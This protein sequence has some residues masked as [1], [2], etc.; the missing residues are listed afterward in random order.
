[1]PATGSHQ[2]ASSIE[3]AYE[4]V[5]VRIDSNQYSDG[6]FLATATRYGYRHMTTESRAI[7][8]FEAGCMDPF[9]RPLFRSRMN[10]MTSYLL[11][12]GGALAR[13]A[14]QG[15][16]TVSI[17]SQHPEDLDDQVEEIFA[18]LPKPEDPAVRTGISFWFREDHGGHR[19]MHRR[20]DPRPWSEIAQGYSEGARDRLDSLMAMREIPHAG[21]LILWH[22]APGTG[23]THALRALAHEW[24]DWCSLHV[25]TDPEHFVGTDVSYLM[26]VLEAMDP[27]SRERD[28]KRLIVLEDAG[29]LL[30][31]DARNQT[32]QGLSRLLNLTDGLI[33]T[34]TNAMV[35]IS[36]NEPVSR[37]H[38]AVHRPGRCFSEIEIGPLS[39]GEANAWLADRGSRTRVSSPRTLAQL[40]A[41]LDGR[42]EGR[43]E[44]QVGFAA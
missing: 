13:I 42:P 29:E 3:L 5:G 39:A 28:R 7:G 22:G 19:L 6:L 20:I 1:M 9:E 31:A 25:I 41:I 17:A 14:I 23:K 32:G 26:N 2:D 11:D 44:R 8:D 30:V 4:S 10:G 18:K 15:T 27:M 36:T 16:A 12:L 34:E 37:L 40:Y 24:R 21:R 33:G 38:P 43:A 35:M